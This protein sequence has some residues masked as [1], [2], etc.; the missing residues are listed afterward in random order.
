MGAFLRNA[1]GLLDP[2]GRRRVLLSNK[3]LPPF[4][5]WDV[6]ALGAAAGLALVEARPFRPAAFPGYTNR[7]GAG[8]RAARTFPCED[9]VTYVF[10]PAAAANAD[11]G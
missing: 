10:E 4:D 6:P 2:A 11:A 9:A 5:T 3:T 7:R 1:R 8:V